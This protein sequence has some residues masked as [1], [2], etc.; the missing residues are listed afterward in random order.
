MII[1][2]SWLIQ[3]VN[4]YLKFLRKGQTIWTTKHRLLAIGLSEISCRMICTTND[5]HQCQGWFSALHPWSQYPLLGIHGSPFSSP[6]PILLGPLLLFIMVY[7]FPLWQAGLCLLVDL[8]CQMSNRAMNISM[9]THIIPQLLFSCPQFH[10][11]YFIYPRLENSHLDVARCGHLLTHSPQYHHLFA[12][13][14]AW[15]DRILLHQCQGEQKP[16]P[17]HHNPHHRCTLNHCLTHLSQCPHYVHF[18]CALMMMMIWEHSLSTDMDRLDL[19]FFPLLEGEPPHLFVRWQ[20]WLLFRLLVIVDQ[21]PWWLPSLV[22]WEN[23][24]KS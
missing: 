20:W 4:H 17:Y 2:Q 14:P 22:L 7:P 1:I 16:Q 19:L 13:P 23:I 10:Y 9:H 15:S 5:S 24:L 21:M 6:G 18:K 12:Y 3:E 11:L 8:N